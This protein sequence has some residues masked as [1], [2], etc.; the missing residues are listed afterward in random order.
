MR[1][2]ELLK[3]PNASTR[4]FEAIIAGDPSLA[5]AL[6]RSGEADPHSQSGHST[7]QEKIMRLGTKGLRSLAWAVTVRNSNFMIT[8]IPGLVD[9]RFTRHSHAVAFL[10]K[11]LYAR[12]FHNRPDVRT[13]W[14]AEEIYLMGLVHDMSYPLL[15]MVAPD[16]HERII[17]F[18]KQGGCT[19]SDAF[20]H[21]YG[22]PMTV[23]TAEIFAKMPGCEDLCN[24]IL[25][26]AAPLSHPEVSDLITCVSYG[27]YLATCPFGMATED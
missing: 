3:N 16:I 24:A 21:F 11:Y 19:V 12:K 27:D 1:L 8:K 20:Q 17:F 5:S 22:Q 25:Y 23:L 2:I 26:L 13:R 7:L 14:S 18:A 9:G 10:S 15:A 4:S 6:L